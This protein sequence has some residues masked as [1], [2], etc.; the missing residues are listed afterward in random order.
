MTINLVDSGRLEVRQQ[1]GGGFDF[2]QASVRVSATFVDMQNRNNPSEPGTAV[3][4]AAQAVDLGGDPS[5]IPDLVA[6][7]PTLYQVIY[8]S[9]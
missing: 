5:S 2:H 7:L 8:D 1:L 6:C 9:V 3:S 4:I